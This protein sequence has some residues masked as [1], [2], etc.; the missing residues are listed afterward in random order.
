MNIESQQ[1]IQI[2][3]FWQKSIDR[4]KLLDRA[5][6]KDINLKSKEVIDIV[7]PRRSGKSSVLKLIIKN[8]NL[9]D[10]FLFIN[11]EDPFF[12]TNN[13]PQIIEEI[14]STFRE[15]F[16][17]NLEYVFFDEIHEITAWEKAIRKLRD[18][19][20]FKI[21]LTGSSSKLLSGEIASLLTGR[22]LSYKVLPLSFSEFLSFKNIEITN[23][24]DQIL[25]EKTIQSAF[26]DYFQVGG[27]P[28]VVVSKNQELLKN[29]FSDLLQKDIVM[30]Y[31]IREKEILEKMAVYVLSNAGKIIS[32]ESLKEMFRISFTAVSAYLEY[33]KEAFL[34]F[35][36]PQFSYSLKDQNKSSKKI[37]AIDQGLANV[38]SF[39]FSEDRGRILENI[40]FLE[41]KR[42]EE[43]IYYYR[44]KNNLEVD[45]LT[46]EK[47]QSKELIQVAWNL[48][49]QA[50]KDR[51]IKSLIQAMT[52]LNLSNGTIVTYSQEEVVEIENKKIFIKPV[53]KWLLPNQ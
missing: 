10:N 34:I 7:G 18:G 3:D 43:E 24:K 23:A 49:D 31:N 20:K 25:N 38:V 48:D 53:Y 14:I 4:E 13:D 16:N 30:R 44:T 46:R 28:E 45:F 2:I 26:E 52:E 15:Y 35:D 9:K 40:V 33:F 21:F 37:Y 41:L 27:F 42:R 51:E 29:Y 17:K 12:I 39:R 32:I 11:F 8:L 22:H 19:E 36:L 50:T 47:N 1:L 6:L 5:V